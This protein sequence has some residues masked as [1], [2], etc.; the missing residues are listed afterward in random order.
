MNRITIATLL[1]LG[2]ALI[3]APAIASETPKT[4]AT[5]GGTLKLDTRLSHGW[6]P[7]GEPANV[8]ATVSVEGA[9]IAAS[10]DRAPLNIALVLDRSTSMSGGKL[11]QAKKASHTLVDMLGPQDRLA[12]VSYGSDVSTHSESRLA[13][14]ANK[15]LLH[16]A[17]NN[18]RLSG[19][20]NLSGGYERARDLV[21]GHNRDET[22]NR[23]ILLS[24]G[25]ANVGI[26]GIPELGSLARRGLDRGVSL[27]TMG[28]GL[29][30]NEDLMTK[31]AVEGA[32]NYY[33]VEDEKAIA[34]IFQKECTGL[35]STVARNTTLEIT[36]APG[37]E[38][39]DLQGFA[40]TTKG[41][42]AT[43]R[44]ADFFARQQKDLLLKLAVSAQGTGKLPI[45]TTRL[46]FDDVTQDDKRVNS[47]ATLA[48]VATDDPKKVKK[49]DR[50]VLKRAQQVETAR[51]FDDAMAKFEEGKAA[52]AAKI[53]S[54]QRQ[55]NS[56]FM[57]QYDFEDDDAFSR[58]DGELQELEKSVK[59]SKPNSRQGK[60]LRKKQKARSY[61]ISNE[62]AAF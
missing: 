53:A 36:M 18:V 61:M 47:S 60:R 56:A 8:F 14:Q 54:S 55:A 34:A 4:R 20:T 37:V 1:A 24:D 21:M 50:A 62:A 45:I 19:S 41:N 29:D 44:L 51:A 32:G 58:V 46:R 31:M 6:L 15:E 9:D 17:I 2:A 49:V 52:E 25:H 11:E 16:N 35:A 26:R 39:L 59:D 57:K 13:T 28:I 43:V 22:V 38:L 33:F 40:Y 7:L 3:A 30:Y 5:A 48:A 42:K 12:V 23:V 10:T 27:T